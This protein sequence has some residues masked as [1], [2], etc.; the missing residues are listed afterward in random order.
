MLVSILNRLSATSM[1]YLAL[2]RMPTPMKIMGRSSS[3]MNAFFN[4]IIPVMPPSAKEIQQA[5]EILGMTPDT[6]Q[7]AYCGSVASELEHSVRLSKTKSQ[8][9]TSR[10]STTLCHLVAN[11]ISQ[12]ATRNGKL[13]CSVPQNYLQQH[14]A[15]KISLNASNGWRLLRAQRLRQKWILRPSWAK[16]FGRSTKTILNE[17]SPSC[18]SHKNSLKKLI[19]RSLMNTRHSNPAFKPTRFHYAPA[20]SLAQR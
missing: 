16:M 4:L 5:L 20:F 15:S 1:D 14:A 3:I 13:G 8:R 17:F 19:L 10:K 11:T 9:G 18:A 2:F 7:C 12:K 6:F